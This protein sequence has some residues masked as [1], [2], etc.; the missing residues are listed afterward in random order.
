MEG[1]AILMYR[2]WSISAPA[3]SMHVTYTA[4]RLATAVNDPEAAAL[5]SVSPVPADDALFIGFLH[6]PLNQGTVTL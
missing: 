2:V 4:H 3:D 1:S 5:F 6:V